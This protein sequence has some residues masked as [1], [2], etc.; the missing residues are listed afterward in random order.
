MINS[1]YQ[2]LAKT[3][4]DAVN[5]AF[6]GDPN[7][8]GSKILSFDCGSVIP[9][10]EVSKNASASND[11]AI[12]LKPISDMVN[13]GSVGSLSVESGSFVINPAK[14]V[15]NLYIILDTKLSNRQFCDHKANFKNRFAAIMVT[16]DGLSFIAPSQIVIFSSNCNDQS[17]LYSAAKVSFYITESPSVVVTPDPELTIRAY[18]L[19]KQFIEDGTTWRLSA[20]FD[21][22]VWAYC[23]FFLFEIPFFAI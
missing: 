15:P 16:K 21:D 19:I 17:T 11:A 14:S 10:V 2:N 5:N 1:D 3:I 6:R 23:S 9:F 12:E 13:S 8:R 7:Y 18:K 20:S 22:K 4:L